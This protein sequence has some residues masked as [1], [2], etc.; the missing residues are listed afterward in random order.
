METNIRVAVVERVGEPTTYVAIAPSYSQF[1]ETVLKAAES[2][3]INEAIVK[4]MKEA[5]VLEVT[6]FPV[7][8]YTPPPQTSPVKESAC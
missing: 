1:G 4:V 3:D 7:A 6:L 2:K 8:P 5:G